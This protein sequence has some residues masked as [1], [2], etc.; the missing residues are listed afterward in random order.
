MLRDLLIPTYHENKI[1][2]GKPDR[3]GGY[4]VDTSLFTNRL[5][6]LGCQN[7]T[8]FEEAYLDIRPEAKIDIYDGGGKCDLADNNDNVTF[9][10]RF[11]K[12]IDDITL[13]NNCVVQMDIEGHEL[14]LLTK[15]PDLSYITQLIIEI[16]MNYA[17]H[18]EAWRHALSHL[19]K[20][21]RLIHL[22]MNNW[23][24]TAKFGV[25]DVL[26]LTY[27]RNDMVSN[28]VIDHRPYPLDMD[29]PNNKNDE[30]DPVLDWWL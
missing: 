8:T 27:L 20:S 12:T 13:Y 11:I 10:K 17:P 7:E 14:N 23:C 28:P 3:D 16:H 24:K 19:N 6:S 26:E 22:H 5:V 25:P 21:H 29:S 15:E 2:I 1:R 9:I 4:I 30:Y 18:Y